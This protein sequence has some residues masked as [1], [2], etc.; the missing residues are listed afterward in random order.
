MSAQRVIQSAVVSM[1]SKRSR[2]TG[3]EQ[4]PTKKKLKMTD[5]CCTKAEEERA[6]QAKSST[7]DHNRKT[8]WRP[9]NVNG[10]S[11]Q[12]DCGPMDAH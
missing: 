4:T 3:I 11:D 6:K 2:H 1:P 5:Q 12:S 7:Q 10:G 9:G 8:E